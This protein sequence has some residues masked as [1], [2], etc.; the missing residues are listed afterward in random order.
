VLACLC[1]DVGTDYD[2]IVRSANFK[3]VI[4]ADVK[5]TVGAG[6]R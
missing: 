5:G 2:A 1:R 4:R 6:A 3:A